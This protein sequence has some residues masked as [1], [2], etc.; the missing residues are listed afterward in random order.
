MSRVTGT[1]AYFGSGWSGQRILFAKE[2]V[3]G[4]LT[5]VVQT[6][7][8]RTLL[9]NGKFQGDN[10]GE[11]GTQVRFAMIPALFTRQFDQAL[12]IGLGT[13]HTL[14]TVARLPFQQI[15]AAV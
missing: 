6:G 12:V 10:S 13:G 11:M 15:D 1:Y 5:S 7:N 14:R 8:L 3:Q 9:S 4:G 2:D